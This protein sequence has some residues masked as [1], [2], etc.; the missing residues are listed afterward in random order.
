MSVTERQ[1]LIR[2]AIAKAEVELE[3][4]RA[5]AAAEVVG[6]LESGERSTRLIDIR[7]RRIALQDDL[8]GL[9]DAL[10][11]LGAGR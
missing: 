6:E 2:A 1:A 8:V 7:A 10:A 11:L 9:Q 3:Q 5:A 4:L